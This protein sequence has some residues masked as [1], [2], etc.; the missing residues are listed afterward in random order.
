MAA[1][2]FL[3]LVNNLVTEVL[4]IQTSAGAAN[5]GD[6]VALDDSGRI[7]NSMMP[8]GIG[9]DTAVIAASEAL[10]AGDWVNVWNSTG[11]KVRKADAT[12]SGK[13]AHGFVLAAVTSGA[14]ATVYFEGT[15]TQVT[16]QT[17]G[18]VF[19]QTT[20]GT[21]GATAPSASGNVVQRLGVAVSTTAVNF[22]GG[23]PVV[24]A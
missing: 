6:I 1:K 11:A 13:E 20:A 19:L 5:A 14:N 22:E 15:N 7:D 2:K 8:V 3:R 9:A 17:P 12:T 4:G 18:P 21:G 23:V 16:A 10:A 24:L